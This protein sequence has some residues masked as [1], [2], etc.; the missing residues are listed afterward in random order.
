MCAIHCPYWFLCD[1]EADQTIARLLTVQII[2]KKLTNF[3]DEVLLLREKACAYS[4]SVQLTF[5]HLQEP[6][7][8]N[9]RTSFMK[10]TAVSLLTY[11]LM[12]NAN[13]AQQGSFTCVMCLTWAKKLLKGQNCKILLNFKKKEKLCEKEE[14]KGP[15]FPFLMHQNINIS[16]R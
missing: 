2:C 3:Q 12:G 11:W 6:I 10:L 5:Y 14:L 4:T 16:G 13:L 1:T 9:G 7:Y 8:N 15:G